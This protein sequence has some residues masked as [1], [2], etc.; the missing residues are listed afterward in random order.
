MRLILVNYISIDTKGLAHTILHMR[1]LLYFGVMLKAPVLYTDMSG[2]ERGVRGYRLPAEWLQLHSF[3][4][5][6]FPSKVF[7][8]MKDT[9]QAQ[10]NITTKAQQLKGHPNFL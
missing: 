6:F 10:Y 2:E 1:R 8:I 4:L 5:F 9:G 3:Y 7:N